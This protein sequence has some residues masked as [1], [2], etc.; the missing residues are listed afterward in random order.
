MRTILQGD[1]MNFFIPNNNF[2]KQKWML[3]IFDTELCTNDFKVIAVSTPS[4]LL[5]PL[6]NTLLTQTGQGDHRNLI[7]SGGG[8]VSLFSNLN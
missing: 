4:Y 3:N 1:V 8:R 6:M 5:W 2:R 7:I